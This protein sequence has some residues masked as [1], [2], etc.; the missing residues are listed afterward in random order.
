MSYSGISRVRSR[1]V[2]E[3]LA[4]K[5]A[6]VEVT[7]AKNGGFGLF[8]IRGRLEQIGGHIEIES[9]PGHG[10][11]VTVMAPLKHREITDGE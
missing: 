8:S 7:A 9:E 4:K 6:E 2:S 1:G 10:T 11:R 3:I 5:S